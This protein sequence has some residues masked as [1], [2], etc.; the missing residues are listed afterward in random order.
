MPSP[1]KLKMLITR[2]TKRPSLV[3]QALVLKAFHYPSKLKIRVVGFRMQRSLAD[4]SHRLAAQMLGFEA[5]GL[6]V[7]GS[8]FRVQGLGFRV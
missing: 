5:L 4:G 3:A 8:G 1:L 7:Y 2:P 6:K